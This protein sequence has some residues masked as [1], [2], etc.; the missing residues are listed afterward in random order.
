MSSGQMILPKKMY[1]RQM[2]LPK[3]MRAQKKAEGLPKTMYQTDGPAK[4]DVPFAPK[5]EAKDS[6]KN[7]DFVSFQLQ[8]K[9]LWQPGRIYLGKCELY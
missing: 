1:S 7:A 2:I 6:S 4:K 5:K 3:K 8:L 9:F